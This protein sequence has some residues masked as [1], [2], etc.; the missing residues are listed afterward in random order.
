MLTSIRNIG[1]APAENIVFSIHDIGKYTLINSLN[2]DGSELTYDVDQNDF[3]IKIERLAPKTY[4][5]LNIQNTDE[6]NKTKRIFIS[7]DK[8]SEEFLIEFIPDKSIA[9]S[10]KKTREL[11]IIATSLIINLIM[12]FI[13][14]RIQTYRFDQ[15][16]LNN[17]GKLDIQYTP[18]WSYY[19]KISIWF[20]ISTHILVLFQM[21]I[22]SMLLQSGVTA[23]NQLDF[24]TYV[25]NYL[26]CDWNIAM[27]WGI[28]VTN[29]LTAIAMVG[30]IFMAFVFALNIP[31][32]PRFQWFLRSPALSE[33][34]VKNI[35][36]S[37]IKPIFVPVETA[38]D[39]I[40]KEKEDV[41]IL[42]DYSDIIGLIAKNEIHRF[43]DPESA[44]TN[45]IKESL[46]DKIHFPSINKKSGLR[47]NF[48]YVQSNEN[49]QDIKEKMD[50]GN[51]RFALVEA[52][53]RIIGI[54]DYSR[55]FDSQTKSLF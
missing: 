31:R 40:L 32:L 37:I 7:H 1:N 49:L 20:I 18:F 13:L 17:L 9:V 24:D 41:L 34:Y 54:I 30:G 12:I 53:K 3:K 4:V 19:F 28:Q 50:S 27:C 25:A 14:R 42:T 45:P 16:R 48:I 55:I 47:E 46:N 29:N 6:G 8:D 5:I 52:E 43:Y 15:I 35:E 38:T 10:S 23:S 26:K 11:G 51:V 44:P 2:T 33:L 21:M 22:Q 36:G 39:K